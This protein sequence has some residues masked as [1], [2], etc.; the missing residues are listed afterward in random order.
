MATTTPVE[1]SIDVVR[2]FTRDVFNGRNYERI[3]DFQ[4]ADYVQH[5]PM[6]GMELHGHDESVEMMR[7]FHDA[8]SDLE[9]TEEFAFGDGEYVCM[10]LTYRGTHDGALMGIPPTDVPAEVKGTLVN[11]LEDGKIAESWVVVDF[12]GLL[13]QVGVVPSMDEFAA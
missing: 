5:G 12:L 3:A 13:Q 4:S 8:F 9:A 2:A 7:T 6:M 11:R 1:Q 10:H